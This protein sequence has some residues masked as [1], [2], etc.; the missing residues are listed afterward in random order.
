[1]IRNEGEEAQ[2]GSIEITE[3]GGDGRCRSQVHVSRFPISFG[4][5]GRGEGAVSMR[6]HVATEEEREGGREDAFVFVIVARRGNNACAPYYSASEVIGLYA[7]GLILIFKNV[8][9]GFY[10]STRSFHTILFRPAWRR[11]AGQVLF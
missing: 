11:R 5:H 4:S 8:L 3:T 1:M 7:R 2:Q 10:Q 6:G 9:K